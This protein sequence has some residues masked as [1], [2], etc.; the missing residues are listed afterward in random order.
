MTLSKQQRRKALNDE[1]VQEKL[2]NKTILNGHPIFTMSLSSHK[3]G[4]I[5]LPHYLTVLEVKSPETADVF[6][7]GYKNNIN[8]YMHMLEF[9]D[10]GMHSYYAIH[11][12][13]WEYFEVRSN[14][15]PMRN[16][17]GKRFN[18]FLRILETHY[19]TPAPILI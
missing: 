10:F 17:E 16:G 3:S 18:E 11:F 6:N 5:V 4:D 12:E 19:L 1:T 2:L 8:Q 15:Y 9:T 7:P 14:P 13:Y